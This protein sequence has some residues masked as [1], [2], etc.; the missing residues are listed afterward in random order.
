[1]ADSQTPSIRSLKKSELVRTYGN[2]GT[3]YWS[4]YFSEEPNAKW[5]DEQR[6]DTVEEMRRSD[7]SVRAVLSA[8]KTPILSTETSIMAA[9]EDDKDKEIAEMVEFQLFNMRRTFQ[10]WLREALSF[11]DFGH[12]VFEK[13][14]MRDGDKIRLIDMEPRIPH[15][16]QSWEINDREKGI[17]QRV[18]N[19]VY[20]KQSNQFGYND[21]EI[22]WEKLFIL[23]NDQE[24]DDVTGMSV[25]RAAYTHY[26]MKTRIYRMQ[27][28]GIERG[29]VGV[30]VGEYPDEVG[31]QDKEDFENA[32]ANLRANESGYILHKPGYKI[33]ILTPS[34]NPMGSTIKDAIDHH[35]RMILLSVLAEFL[36]LGGAG[37][38][39]FALS[40]D[41]S[42]FFLQHLQEKADYISEQINLLIK[43]I[44]DLNYT[45][46][47]AYP[48]FH[49]S[50]LGTVDFKEV[51]DILKTLVDANLIDAGDTE[52]QKFM[53]ASLRLPELKDESVEEME[54]KKLADELE[55]ME[56]AGDEFD[57]VNDGFDEE[58]MENAK[59]T[60]KKGEDGDEADTE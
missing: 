18:R 46:V 43:E 31:P 19:N 36:D 47:V 20:N 5:R 9:S 2:S 8:L 4:G 38:G 6:V 25:L 52:I 32:L 16:I 39:S 54:A 37:T 55:T 44:V 35:S 53:R 21:Y 50:S 11:L 41:Q 45:G 56:G 49:F 42:S 59:P 24:G 10:A 28:V 34:N 3:E 33:S 26:F 7:A 22:P 58:P 27:A 12:Y 13:I 29:A 51:S 48:T 40:K 15:S 30:P 60:E 17:T 1:M 14:W 57:F 23:T